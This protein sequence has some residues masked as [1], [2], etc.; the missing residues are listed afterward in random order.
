MKNKKKIII[1]SM[2]IIAII[3]AIISILFVI[4]DSNN[5]DEKDSNDIDT[6]Y[7]E[8]KI[9][10]TDQLIEDLEHYLKDS[11]TDNFKAQKD[12]NDMLNASFDYSKKTMYPHVCAED[13]L[14]YIK[15]LNGKL[16]S[17]K[18]K[19]NTITINCKENGNLKY[20]TKISNYY[21]INSENLENNIE[22]FDESG[23]T[24]GKNVSQVKENYINNYKNSCNTYDYKTI[25][26]YA[27][28]YNGKDV[29]FTGEVV[30]VIEESKSISSYRINVTKD[31][32]GYYD[33]TVFVTFTNAFDANTPRILED[34][35]VTFY[36]KL[37]NL[38][39]YETVL[40]SSLTIPSV[41]AVYIEIKK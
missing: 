2:I 14:Y 27:E 3:A 20:T 31:K 21:L 24:L 30:Q 25:F 5:I 4:N 13:S 32:W 6:P 9:S 33:D 35:I 38:Y 41:N 26:R 12:E 1:I 34:D 19:I 17:N 37:G 18:G 15:M 22:F 23:N 36:G 29:K 16:I 39:T 8:E 28:D 10:D 40:G 11:D 7:Q